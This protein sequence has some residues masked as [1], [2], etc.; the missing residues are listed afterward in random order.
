MNKLTN[1]IK[2]YEWGCPKFIPEF[3]GLE[4]TE[5][6]YAEMWMGT[7]PGAPSR[8]ELDNKTAGLNEVHGELPF[9]FKLLGIDKPLS[10]QVHPDKE[11]AENGFKKEEEKGIP[12]SSPERNYKDSNHK[13]EI[14][15][16]LSPFTMMAGFRKPLDTLSSFKELLTFAPALNQLFSPLVETLQKESL[17]SFY[18]TLLKFTKDDCKFVFSTL[19]DNKVDEHPGEQIIPQSWTL[20]KKFAALYPGDISVLSPLF[21]NVLNLEPGQAVFI[22]AGILHAYISGFGIELMSS[23]DNVLR[24]GLTPKHIDIDELLSITHFEP[25]YPNVLNPSD[26]DWF[27]YNTPSKDFLLARLN[28]NNNEKILPLKTKAICIVTSGELTADGIPFKKG[29]SFFVSDKYLNNKEII[30]TGQYTLF[31]ATDC[32]GCS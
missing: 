9:L 31:A 4:N 10:I 12:L 24:A 22:P 15:C 26:D 8:I 11:Q 16:A 7:H 2:H 5:L 23:S 18:K 17:I 29:E 28:G 6:P 14:M 20:M 32:C 13:P 30:L 19:F 3:L 25:Y 27:C 1:Q 21:L